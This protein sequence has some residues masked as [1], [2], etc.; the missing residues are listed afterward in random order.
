MTAV[1]T[2]AVVVLA[3]LCVL[4]CVL[5]LAVIRKL[6]RHDE[7]LRGVAP[8]SS[9]PTIAVGT[10]VPPFSRSSTG[11]PL[12]EAELHGRPTLVAFAAPGCSGC[13]VARPALLERLAADQAAGHPG[14]VVLAGDLG[15]TTALVEEFAPHARVVVESPEQGSLHT[16]FQ[17]I[18]YPAYAVVGG[19]GRVTAVGAAL[20][21]VPSAVPTTSRS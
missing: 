1:L 10:P 21:D 14:V 8:S 15:D 16:A 7:Q 18:G 20:Q 5:T 4:N 2:T 11:G 19:D 13:E 9:A 12:S 3:A 17:V 6:R